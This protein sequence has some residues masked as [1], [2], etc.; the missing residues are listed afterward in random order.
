MEKSYADK[1]VSVFRP[2]YLG[3]L[4]K[5]KQGRERCE[6]T[7]A[8][9]YKERDEIKGDIKIAFATNAKSQVE[10]LG[11]FQPK[12]TESPV[13]IPTREL[14]TLCPWFLPLYDHY[15]IEFEE[16]WRDTVSLLGKPLVRASRPKF[17]NTIEEAMHGKVRVDNQSGKFYLQTAEGKMEMPLVAEG[18]RKLA[19]LAHLSSTGTFSE[20]GILF[21][22]VP[23]TNL[24]PKL[25]KTVAEV[26]I[27]IAASNAQIFIATHS[28][29]LLRE[30]EILLNQRKYKKV[31]RR[32]FA[33]A[34]Q[35]KHIVLEQSDMV[36]N[37]QTLVMLKEA[38]DQADRFLEI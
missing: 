25:I 4:V 18:L 12:L 38:L 31:P 34:S 32:W 24:N 29:F 30:L 7:L 5:R 15:H 11:Q 19:M 36:N 9:Q 3:R 26:I 33:L 22:D 8:L 14:V 21:W 27:A 37:I 10:I 13:Y 17:L 28:L 2:E 20:K 23:E 16:T 1:L 35:D 6:L